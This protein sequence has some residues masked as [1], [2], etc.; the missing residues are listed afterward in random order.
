MVN[1]GIIEMTSH[2]VLVPVIVHNGR[3]RLVLLLNML[4][5]IIQLVGLIGKLLYTKMHWS[6]DL[7]VFA[8]SPI[9]LVT[10][11]GP[12]DFLV[13]IK[14]AF[15]LF[16]LFFYLFYFLIVLLLGLYLLVV[17]VWLFWLH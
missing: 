4:N 7:W 13:K 11:V 14:L 1:L 17:A 5:R 10:Y 6:F 3:L 12:S 16:W 2:V 15:L 9:V 8:E